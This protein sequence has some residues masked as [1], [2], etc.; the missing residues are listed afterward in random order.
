ML[1]FVLKP[2]HLVVLCVASY[3]N[4]EQQRIIEY[5]EVENQVLR[6]NPDPHVR[7]QVFTGTSEAGVSG[8]RF[9]CV[10]WLARAG[11]FFA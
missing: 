4:R 10:F 3:L 1:E 7:D 8:G 6:E 9:H 2:W 11:V 5:L